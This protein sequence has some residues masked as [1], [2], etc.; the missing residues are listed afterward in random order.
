MLLG[1]FLLYFSLN[2]SP[3]EQQINSHFRPVALAP[4]QGER[5]GKSKAI[6]QVECELPPADEN[7]DEETLSQPVQKPAALC[8]I[9][10]RLARQ[11]GFHKH[12]V[13]GLGLFPEAV[14]KAK[15]AKGLAVQG[16]GSVTGY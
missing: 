13:E 1:Q 6:A 14:K 3:S 7:V 8:H 12:S 5:P 10:L 11:K 2:C 16:G 9:I 15:I 4:L